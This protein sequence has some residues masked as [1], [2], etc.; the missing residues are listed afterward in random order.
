MSR[1]PRE[2][3]VIPTE[4]VTRCRNPTEVARYAAG[5]IAAAAWQAVQ[6]RGQFRLA[7]SGGTTPLPMFDE[8]TRLEVPWS[9]IHLFQVDERVAPLGDPA[10]NLTALDSH[11]IRFVPLPAD[12][13]H[14]MPVEAI[15]RVDAAALYAEQLRRVGGNPPV[16]DL[17]HLGLGSDGHTASLVPGDLVLEATSDVA[18]TG[19]YQGHR[20]MT[21]TFPVL[22]RAR[23]ILWVVSGDEKRQMVDRLLWGDRSIP[24]GRVAQDVA[25]VV[26]DSD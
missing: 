9:R 18:L 22:A 24:A 14:R 2:L 19:M 15:D 16:L 4:R 3:V 25:E 23:A 6:R 5:V 7:V 20:R 1:S 26:T 8:L 21:L 13:V 12:Q 17:I 11:L 10:R